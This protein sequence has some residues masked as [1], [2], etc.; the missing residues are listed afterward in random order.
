M[1]KIVIT[2]LLI[3]VSLGVKAHD[4]VVDGI[5]Y[6]LNRTNYTAEVTFK[7]P[8]MIN[9][10][11]GFIT[12]PETI[13]YG[14]AQYIVTSIGKQAFFYCESLVSIT[15]PN[16]I[17]TIGEEAFIQC[18]TLTSLS[19]PNSVT[20]ISSNAFENC[21]SL[22][23][24]TIGEGVQTIGS[25]AFQDCHSLKSVRVPNQVVSIG[26]YCF[27]DC[28][29]LTSISIGKNVRVIGQYALACMNSSRKLKDIY[30]YAEQ[31]PT[32]ASA[33][34][35]FIY[36]PDE[37]TTLH[38]PSSALSLYSTTEQWSRFKHIV[39]LTDEEINDNN[40]N[41][42][43][44]VSTSPEDGAK[45]VA[46]DVQPRMTFS[47]NVATNYNMTGF[48]I[49]N[50]CLKTDDGKVVPRT[51]N[52]DGF[53][54]WLKPTQPL[55]P[56]TRYTMVI[57][58]GY[59]KSVETNVPSTQDFV[60]S[61][62]TKEESVSGEL[63]GTFGI[64]N[65]T[66]GVLN[67]NEASIVIEMENTTNT[68]YKGHF[69]FYFYFGEEMSLGYSWWPSEDRDDVVISPGNSTYQFIHTVE[70]M[71]PCKFVAYFFP[72]VGERIELGSVVIS[73]K[74]FLGDANGDGNV[75]VTDIVEIV[76]DILGHPSDKFDP[77]A[78]DVNGDGMVNVTDNV[79]VVN[80]ILASD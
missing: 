9:T 62:T 50:I 14:G 39:S 60:F 54:Y 32:T 76:N 31:V 41:E 57:P 49:D 74:M 8:S 46:L 45:D 77:I 53:S 16:T 75:N 21:S 68:T 67:G 47:T 2:F 42:I 63:T 10:Y 59:I 38:V 48:K 30:C 18:L 17:Q 70:G 28:N 6:N 19:I 23:D 66:N 27:Y 24:V 43:V 4:A 25:R 80:I 34:F 7:F 22:L 13:T 52:S 55:A 29:S 12:I 65:V 3:I 36:E 71:L 37:Q 35:D 5:Y 20:N 58:A 78:A 61:F 15:I 56:N 11:E 40:I 26:A 72:E 73:S 51:L 64:S 1:R 79:I 69:G 33:I 44:L